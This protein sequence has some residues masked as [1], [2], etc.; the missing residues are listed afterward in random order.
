MSFLE[1]I[2]RNKQLERQ[3]VTSEEEAMSDPAPPKE[4]LPVV[5]GFKGLFEES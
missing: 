4:E 1:N 5:Q 3:G 2:Q